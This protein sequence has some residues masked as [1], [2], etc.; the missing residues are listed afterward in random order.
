MIL[1]LP[2]RQP[3]DFEGKRKNR[4]LRRQLRSYKQFGLSE[5]FDA[6]HHEQHG[7]IFRITPTNKKQ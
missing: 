4:T 3:V 7:T 6:A 1:G 5:S 2:Q